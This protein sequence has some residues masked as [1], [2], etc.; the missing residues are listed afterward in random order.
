MVLRRELYRFNLAE[1]GEGEDESR[2][3]LLLID[4]TGVRFIRRPG[5]QDYWNTHTQLL[6]YLYANVDEL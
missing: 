1:Q 3:E 4:F 5:A 6:L 2:P